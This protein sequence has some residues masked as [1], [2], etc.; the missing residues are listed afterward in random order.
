MPRDLPPQ[1]RQPV[2]PAPGSLN[3]VALD[4]PGVHQQ[5]EHVADGVEAVAEGQELALLMV[6]FGEHDDDRHDVPL[7]QQLDTVHG[8]VM[9]HVEKSIFV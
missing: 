6:G 4:E 7:G 9:L 8:C 1:R 5:G 3:P 2:P